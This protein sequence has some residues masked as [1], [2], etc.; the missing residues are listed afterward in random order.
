MS[1]LFPLS[2]FS[3]HRIYVYPEIWCNI[4]SM[5]A[6]QS[7]LCLTH[8]D[9]HVVT[10]DTWPQGWREMLVTFWCPC[11]STLCKTLDALISWNCR[12]LSCQ[13]ILTNT[14][15][16]YW[17][18]FSSNRLILDSIIPTNSTNI[19]LYVEH[20]QEPFICVWPRKV[21]CWIWSQKPVENRSSK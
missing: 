12:K 7:S 3:Y 14:F 13:S 17:V 6:P 21:Q 19:C 9:S 8:C 4:V 18:L 2:P 11:C 20:I 10:V 15:Q 1:N 16:H 5:G